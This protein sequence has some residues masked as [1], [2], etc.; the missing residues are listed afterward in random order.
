MSNPLLTSTILPPFSKIK[1][2]HIQAAVEQGIADCR[3]KID[4]VLAQTAPFTWDNL[5]APLEETDDALGKIW[6]PASHMNSVVSTEEW[7]AAHDACL[8]LLSE[9]GTFVGQHQPLYQAYKSLRASAE[10]EQMTQAQQTVIEHSLR[11]F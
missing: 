9:Y 3:S 4:E 8:P 6:S 7:R 11:D 2:E 1:P 5:V 10:F